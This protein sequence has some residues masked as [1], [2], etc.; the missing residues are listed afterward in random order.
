AHGSRSSCHVLY[1][2][3]RKEPHDASTGFGALQDFS[4]QQCLRV[5][6]AAEDN[7]V[8]LM[9]TTTGAHQCFPVIWPQVWPCSEQQ[10]FH[11]PASFRSPPQQTRRYYTA[12]IGNQQVARP[13]I[14]A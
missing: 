1:A 3:L 5:C 14:L 11:G 13:Q 9:Q 6:L 4:M 10:D 7:A 12:L 2:A 8:A